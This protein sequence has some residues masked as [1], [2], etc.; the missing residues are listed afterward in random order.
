T[1][2]L[3]P[4]VQQVKIGGTV[5]RYLAAA[6]LPRS[7]RVI[8]VAGA[9]ALDRA[10]GRPM[11]DRMDT[12]VRTM[13]S[14]PGPMAPEFQ[15]LTADGQQTTLL[16]A[17]TGPIYGGFYGWARGGMGEIQWVIL[18]NGKSVLAQHEP[19]MC[20]PFTV[21]LLRFYLTY[22]HGSVPD[23][24]SLLAAQLSPAIPAAD[25]GIT[26]DRIQAAAG[27]L[28]KLGLLRGS[29]L[30][31]DSSDLNLYATM[32]HAELAALLGHAVGQSGNAVALAG[33][34]DAP[35]TVDAVMTALI[36]AIGRRRCAG[37]PWLRLLPRRQGLLRISSEH[38]QDCVHQLCRHRASGAERYPAGAAYVFGAVSHPGSDVAG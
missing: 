34:P 5:T 27:R 20:H 17:N 11:G 37:E 35:V 3:V 16:R 1:D 22:P 9:P 38:W 7:V 8:A 23:G 21:K 15:G 31:T 10:W 36:G 19:V 6:P 26:S 33:S 24:N 14:F 30:A 13:H 12:V 29:T 25:G 32:T 28:N 18:E 2:L 4:T